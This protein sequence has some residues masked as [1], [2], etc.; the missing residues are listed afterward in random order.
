MPKLRHAIAV[1]A[2]FAATAAAAQ[3]SVTQ[4]PRPPATRP[5]PVDPAPAAKPGY[6]VKEG[7]DHWLS[8]DFVGK[9]VYGPDREKV[10]TISDLLFEKSGRI[11]AAVVGVGGFL[12]MGEKE[13]AVP[14]GDLQFSTQDGKRV[15]T[16]NA[17]RQALKAAPSFVRSETS[18]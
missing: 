7:A 16:M 2:V 18:G 4:P 9:D 5:A 8:S 13:V 14:F 11:A 17:T 15:I 12:G 3:Q 10:G 1:L 6:V